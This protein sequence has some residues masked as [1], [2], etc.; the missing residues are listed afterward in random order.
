MSRLPAAVLASGGGTNLQ[1]LL[2]R[3]DREDAYRIGLVVSD[4]EEAGAL[5]RARA[6]GREARVV[7]VPGREPGEV[8]RETLELFRERNVRLVLLAGYLRLVPPGVVDVYRGRILNVHPALLPAFG[9]EGMYGRRVHRAVL[10]S[11]VKISGPTIHLVDEAYDRGS[12]VAQWP[13]PVLESDTEETLAERVLRVEHLLYPAAAG[14][15]ARAVAEG[16]EPAAFSPPA[17]PFT[18]DPDL[19]P[20]ELQAAVRRAFPRG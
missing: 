14:H 13:V 19:A 6:A 11:G 8:A 15:V 1:A 9:G 18:S 12:I 7:P 20:E 16:R 3:E 5:E 2:D 10:E 4:R 17:L